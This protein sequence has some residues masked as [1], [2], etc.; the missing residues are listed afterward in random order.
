MAEAHRS[1]QAQMGSGFGLDPVAPAPPAGP[2]RL[3][4]QHLSQGNLPSRGHKAV[5]ADCALR[6]V[7]PS[8][9]GRVDRELVAD[10]GAYAC[11][12]AGHGDSASSQQ[13][14]TDA[15]PGALQARRGWGSRTS[16]PVRHWLLWTI[17]SPACSALSLAHM[18]SCR[19]MAARQHVLLVPGFF[20]FANVGD[21]AYFGHVRDA[22]R[23]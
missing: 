17:A 19:P 18:L 21:F 2:G 6:R 22:L 5:R 13:P 4:R 3:Q 12:Q 11:V 10:A 1:D 16:S 14:A 23:N 20:G 8:C 7:T 15:A 9:T